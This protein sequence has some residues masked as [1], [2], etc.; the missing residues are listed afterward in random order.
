MKA[1]AS[2]RWRP[3]EQLR[4]HRA[5][6]P[7][8]RKKEVF[9]DTQPQ[10]GG[11]KAGIEIGPDGEK[12]GNIVCYPSFDPNCIVVREPKKGALDSTGFLSLPDPV[13]FHDDTLVKATAEINEILVKVLAKREPRKGDL[14]VTLSKEGPMLVWVRSTAKA[15]ED[16]RGVSTMKHD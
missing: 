5:H 6:Q 9:V 16:I 13:P 1:S 15:V 14:H 12:T 11:F 7:N 4:Y 8:N 2:R 10:P 3:R